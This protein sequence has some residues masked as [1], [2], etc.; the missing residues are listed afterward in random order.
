MESL[1][2]KFYE[3]LTTIQTNVVRDFILKEIGIIALSA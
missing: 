1:R 3:K 2:T